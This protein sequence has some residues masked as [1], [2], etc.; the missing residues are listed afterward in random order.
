[1]KEQPRRPAA[2]PYRAIVMK[3]CLA[4]GGDLQLAPGEIR[5]LCPPHFDVWK[6]RRTKH[7]IEP[8]CEKVPG[9]KTTSGW[10]RG[11][12]LSMWAKA[13]RDKASAYHRKVRERREAEG[14]KRVQAPKRAYGVPCAECGAERKKKRNATPYCF[15]CLQKQGRKKAG[16][17]PRTTYPEVKPKLDLAGRQI[18]RLTVTSDYSRGKWRCVCACGREC[19][20]ITSSLN[21]SR[22]KKPTQ[23]CGCYRREA[24]LQP[25][26]LARF[27]AAG[28]RFRPGQNKLPP[29]PERETP[30]Q[31]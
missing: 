21:G 22:N 25:A 18:G 4:C 13:N 10:C 24:A 17:R 12:Y 14:K 16:C 26:R 28:T 6:R 20:I 19:W 30:E 15:P 2:R 11:H 7:C 9:P 5:G 29:R 31:N 8:G 27:M 3:H 1:M 23:S